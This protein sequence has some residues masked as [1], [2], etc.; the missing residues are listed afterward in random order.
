MPSRVT[1]HKASVQSAVLAALRLQERTQTGKSKY[2]YATG[3]GVAIAD[4]PP[5]FGQQ[6]ISVSANGEVKGAPHA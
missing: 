5:P 3:I 6:Y 2:I 1:Y 4:E